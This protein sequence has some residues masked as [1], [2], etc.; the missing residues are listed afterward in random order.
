[1]KC[2]LLLFASM[3]LLVTISSCQYDK[4][5]THVVEVGGAFVTHD[6]KVI[7]TGFGSAFVA[8]YK[9]QHFLVTNYHIMTDRFAPDTTQ[10]ED[11]PLIEPNTMLVLFRDAKNSRINNPIIIKKG[12]T[13]LYYSIPADPITRQTMD[14]AVI[15][16]NKMPENAVDP[17]IDFDAIDTTWKIEGN[18]PLLVCGF[19]FDSSFSL[20]DPIS[21]TVYSVPG[22][23]FDYNFPFVFAPKKIEIHGDSGSP[24]YALIKGQKKLVGMVAMSMVA[25]LSLQPSFMAG[26]DPNITIHVFVGLR[27]I[28]ES[29]QACYDRSYP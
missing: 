18:T 3:L 10:S 20:V 9:G 29:L 14:I 8:R 22:R 6:R 24:V 15:S 1:M 17:S 28:R 2:S 26:L 25:P 7:S 13:R 12:D 4:I 19:K 11:K 21:D 5:M 16:L 27:I 23:S